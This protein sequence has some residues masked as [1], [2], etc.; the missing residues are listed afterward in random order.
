MHI[1][2]Q[3]NR[4]VSKTFSKSVNR[5]EWRYQDPVYTYYYYRDVEKEATAD[6]TGQDNV[7]NVV[8]YVQYRAK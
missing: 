5:T 8:M 2:H 7:S 6:P 3:K 4:S 1:G